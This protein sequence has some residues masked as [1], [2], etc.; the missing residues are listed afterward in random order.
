M[1]L[2]K[3]IVTLK[4]F[5]SISHSIMFKL[6]AVDVVLFP[7]RKGT[8]REAAVLLNI[9]FS[10]QSHIGPKTNLSGAAENEKPYM[11]TTQL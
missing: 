11:K 1:N 4:K 8:E 10:S 9:L 6:T 2:D 7:D 5:T 3:V